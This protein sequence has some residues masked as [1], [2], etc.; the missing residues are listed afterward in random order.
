MYVAYEYKHC[1]FIRF[2][3]HDLCVE[4][5]LRGHVKRELASSTQLMREVDD[6]QQQRLE[7][8]SIFCIDMLNI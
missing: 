3:S 8:G 5:E 1:V 6:G 4:C 7:T 2:A